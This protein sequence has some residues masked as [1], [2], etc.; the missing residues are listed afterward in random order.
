MIEGT[1]C[2][3]RLGKPGCGKSLDQTEQDVLEHLKMGV[4]VYCCYWI[5]WKG[6]KKE[7]GTWYQNFHYFQPTKEG[8]ESIKD[9]RNCVVVFDELAQIFDPRDW[10]E[11]GS[12]VRRW[13]QL[14]RHFHVDIYANTQDVSLV[15]KS[16][17]I[18]ADEWQLIERIEET[19]LSQF[20]LD[21]FRIKRIKIR[22]DY[23]SWQQLKKMANGWELGEDVAIDNHWKTV[24]YKIEKIIHRELEDNKEELIH[25]YCNKCMSRQGKRVLKGKENEIGA[26]FVPHK[27]GGEWKWKEEAEELY[28]NKHKDTRLVIRESGLYDTD[29]TPES[30]EIKVKW[31]AFVP[32]P[33]G[34]RDI[35]HK[36]LLS[37]AQNKLKQELTDTYNRESSL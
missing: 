25:L 21:L 18:V 12:E 31:K 10:N 17:G 14:H 7:D 13:F 23:L 22:K 1:R 3:I 6:Y 26:I 29:Y 34:H 32:S 33:Y 30:K 9:K 16:V 27:K 19:W 5:N 11:E 8:W 24:S 20:I 4:D 36:G 37:D 28:C 2:V 35:E 15:A